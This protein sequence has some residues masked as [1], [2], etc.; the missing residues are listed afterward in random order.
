MNPERWQKLQEVYFTVTVLEPKA[1]AAFL[2]QACRGD[3]AMREELDSLLDCENKIGE[4]LEQTAIEALVAE[5]GADI[6]DDEIESPADL[7]GMVVD[8]RYI[9]RE[10][11]GSGGT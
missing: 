1:R 4:F 5:Y 9:V 10:H 8:D 3:I 2:E 11:I 7:V 6:V